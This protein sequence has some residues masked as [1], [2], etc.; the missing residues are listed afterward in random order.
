MKMQVTLRQVE[1]LS[2]MGSADSGHA[3]AL[4]APTALGGLGT[5]SRPLELMLMGIAGC[6]SMDVYAILRKKKTPIEHF[7]VQVE[8]EKTEEHPQRITSIRLTYVLT[9][10]EIKPEDVERAIELTDQKYCGAIA[11]IRSS[12]EVTHQY[13]IIVPEN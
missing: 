6:A 1:G 10:K 3:V 2:L 12:V 5:G 9:G 8:A 11:M 13:R 4:D 7:E